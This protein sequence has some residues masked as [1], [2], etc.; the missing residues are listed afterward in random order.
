MLKSNLLEEL[1]TPIEKKALK[2]F[3]NIVNRFLGNNK[4]DYAEIVEN[5]IDNLKIVGCN[6]LIKVY[7]FLYI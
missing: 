4:Q 5:Q 1:T 6:I 3:R 2:A 7:L